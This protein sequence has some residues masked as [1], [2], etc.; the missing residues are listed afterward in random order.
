M[1]PDEIHNWMQPP[2]EMLESFG[3][4]LA[5]EVEKRT[6]ASQDR[7]YVQIA[8]REDLMSE[9]RS[10]QSRQAA[11]RE[12]LRL[13]K[14][15]A[16]MLM[17]E[18]DT[19]LAELARVKKAKSAVELELREEKRGFRIMNGL[20][21]KIGSELDSLKK[22]LNEAELE[23]HMLQ[24]EKLKRVLSD[25]HPPRVKRANKGKITPRGD[26]S[27]QMFYYSLS[28]LCTYRLAL[29]NLFPAF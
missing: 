25:V 19:A 8:T 1:W 18:R 4:M 16:T 14:E 9:F 13:I 3:D 20:V 5:D 10:L 17:K 2:V 24:R 23:R 15:E 6:K 12:G 7:L 29:I 26:R 22:A 27:N 11:E 28:L 21:S